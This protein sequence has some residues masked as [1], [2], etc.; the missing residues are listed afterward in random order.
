L[1]VSDLENQVELVDVVANAAFI[2]LFCNSLKTLKITRFRRKTVISTVYEPQKVVAEG[3]VSTWWIG[4]VK[5][6]NFAVAA[7]LEIYFVSQ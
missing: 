7:L 3:H 6:G 4:S 5:C 2:E 1:L